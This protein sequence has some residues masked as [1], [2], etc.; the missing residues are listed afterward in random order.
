MIAKYRMTLLFSVIAV[1]PV[2]KMA[3]KERSKFFREG[4]N[5]ST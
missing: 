1:T 4:R 3:K 5:E 2:Q